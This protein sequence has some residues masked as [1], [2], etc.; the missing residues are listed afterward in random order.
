[1]KIFSIR[2]GNKYGPEYEDYLRSKLPSIQFINDTIQPYVLQWN[3]LRLFKECGHEPICLIDC[4]VS[5]VGEYMELFEYPIKRGQF[6]SIPSWWN[7][8]DPKRGYQ[9]N[10]GFYKF[11]PQDTQYIWSKF[12][13]DP[14]K[15]MSHYV[16]NGTTIGPLNGE[17][18]FVE[19]SVKERLE[20]I[21]APG[22]WV[23]QWNED[24]QFKRYDYMES[25]YP[26]DYIYDGE[27]NPKIKLVHHQHQPSRE[28]GN[29]RLKFLQYQ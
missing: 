2:V 14:Y 9:I 23:T 26:G 5:L 7:D 19:D 22:E 25:M 16:K 10:G 28:P 20:L 15:W 3:K 11:Y 6:L 12:L 13:K 17:Q 8:T 1:M 21:L 24:W 29:I 18:Y 4:D 27:L